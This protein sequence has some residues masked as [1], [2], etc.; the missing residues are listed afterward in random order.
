MPEEPFILPTLFLFTS[1]MSN[2]GGSSIVS[3]T[4]LPF[5]FTLPYTFCEQIFNLPVYGAKIIFCPGCDLIIQFCREP[6]RDL[7][8]RSALCH[9]ST[10]FLNLQPA[11]HRDFHR[12]RQEDWRP[13]QLFAPHLIRLPDS[14]SDA[15]VPSQ[16]Y[17][18]LRQ[19]SSFSHQ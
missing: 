10:D 12:A 2:S 16:P 19:R 17:R 6:E 9:I 5:F 18:L 14:H 4:Y 7:F 3:D 15:P 8:L 1:Q 13:W 11:V